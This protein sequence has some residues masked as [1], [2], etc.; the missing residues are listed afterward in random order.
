MLPRALAEFDKLRAPHKA[1]E[2]TADPNSPEWESAH[3]GSNCFKVL[4]N[5]LYG[6]T[7]NEYG[8]FFDPDIG[9]S[10]TRIGRWLLKHVIAEAKSWGIEVVYADTDGTYNMGC[11]RGRF[12][13]FVR[14]C[15]KILFPRLLKEQGCVSNYIKL[16]FEKTFGAI[17]FPI[18]KDGNPSAKRYAGKFSFYAGNASNK[19]EIKGLELKRGDSNR[20]ARELQQEIIDLIL[21][22]GIEKAPDIVARFR[23]RVMFEDLPLKLVSISRS[24]KELSTYK[25][26]M[27]KDGTPGKQPPH[28]RIA[29]QLQDRGIDVSEGTRISYV[30]TVDGP[31]AAQDYT[32]NVDRKSLWNK[33]VYPPTERLLWGSLPN[34]N[35]KKYRIKR[36]ICEM[37]LKLL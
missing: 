28:V 13:D 27:K 12:G 30:N 20:L 3:R 1:I 8:R 36:Q 29:K 17:V 18:G 7:L 21:G 9:G 14:H 24:L 37:Q 33:A 31:V 19:I 26:R 15:N 35:W 22:G 11:T 4:R 16:E 2:K 25:Q 34:H 23:E 5:S 10:V 6:C 32:G